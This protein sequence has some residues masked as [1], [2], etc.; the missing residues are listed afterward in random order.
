MRET[1]AYPCACRTL[2]GSMREMLE[3]TVDDEEMF[4]E[5]DDDIEFE[6]RGGAS[7]TWDC[8]TSRGAGHRRL[9]L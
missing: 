8:L 3:Q 1:G 6:S 9:G 2:T 4:A 7:G 5:A